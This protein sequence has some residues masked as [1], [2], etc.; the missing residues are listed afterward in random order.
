VADVLDRTGATLAVVADGFLGR[1]QVA[2]LHA[3]AG[4]LFA[5]S[6]LGAEADVVEGLPGL[7]AIVRIGEGSLDGTV[8]FD[9]L[10]ETGRSISEEEIDA[11][12]S[13]VTG[14][15]IA[16]ILFTS[17]TTGRSKGV[18]SAHSQTVA[19][20]RVWASTGQVTEA[21]R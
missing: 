7:R 19:A 14:D 1:D 18:L 3:A 11:I 8:D 20:S 13:A 2:E 12:A 21:D 4:D 17:G 9:A 15:D 5:A 16:D 6:E 10:A